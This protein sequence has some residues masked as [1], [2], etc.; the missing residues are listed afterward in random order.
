[1]TTK[2]RTPS[3]GRGETR[4]VTNGK[5]KRWA[6][7]FAAGVALA[8]PVRAGVEDVVV[9]FK[10][11]FDLGYTDMA[12]NVVHRYRTSMIDEALT[13]VD[14]N[15]DL[16]P[17]QQFVWTLAGWPLARIAGDWPGQSAERRA[18]VMAAFR[19]GR[20][21]VHALPF[22]LHTETLEPEDVVRGLEFARD[23]TRGA[24]LNLPRDAKMTDVPCHTWLLPTVL[25]RAGVEFL[26]LGC[27]A[28]SRSPEVPPLFWWEGPDGSRLLTM[29]TAESYGTGL[30]PP[31][32]WPYPV[33]LA[34][35][36]T[37]DNHGPPAPEE[38]RNLLAEAR[39][40][41]PGVRVRI[42]RLSDFSD[43][44]LARSPVVPVVRGDMPDTWIHGPQCD[45]A[46]AAMARRIRPRLE[47]AEILHTLLGVWG[48]AAADPAAVLAEAREH[49]LLY[50]EHTWGGALWWVVN[51]SGGARMPYGEAWQRERASGRLARIESSWEEHSAYIRRAAGLLEPI[52]RRQLDTLAAALDGQGPRRVV[53]NPLP[54]PRGGWVDAGDGSPGEWVEEVPALGYRRLPSVPGTASAEGPREAAAAAMPEN[55]TTV[56]AMENHWFRLALDPERARVVSLV[57]RRS[58]RDWADPEAPHGLGQV[59]LERFSAED[60]GAFVHAYV[61]IRADWATNELGKPNL[62]PSSEAPYR[63]WTPRQ[64]R[65]RILRGPHQTEARMETVGEG[66]LPAVTTRWILPAHAPYLDLEVTL[67]D[68]AADPWPEA[69]WIALPF[70]LAEP[71]FRLGR[72]GSI[73][74]PATDIVPGANRHL[75]AV[76]TG[77]ALLEGDDG[78]GV[79]LCPLDSGL[80]SLGEPG[81]WKYSREDPPRRAAVY[82]N[83]YNNQW[84]TNFR[85]WNGGTW[86]TRV[87]LWV[88]D[89][90]DA[91][92]SLITPALEARYPLLVGSAAAS[93][94]RLPASAEGLATDRRGILV[95]ALGADPDAVGGGLRLR[96]WE[97]AGRSGDVEVRL[98][99]SLAQGTVEAIDLR[100][101]T[102]P[103][104]RLTRDGSGRLR[105]ALPAFAPATVRLLR[106][107]P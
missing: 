21:A 86:T 28:A 82:V 13:V 83:V 25:R 31:A 60:A 46:G 70:D 100:G 7:L 39:A 23:L 81:C 51:Y 62:P 103:E 66:P 98:P 20:F 88:F 17:D 105:M 59:V 87:R 10:T 3:G 34:L 73:V 40:K 45:P 65:L 48:V 18:R 8:A 107:H 64:A 12:S 93:S 95:T 106:P 15:R 33:W 24:G 53:F 68:K 92:T 22:T 49:S 38:V 99:A 69:I 91:E 43:A 58:G 56:A 1:M 84:T 50:G 14:R 6:T 97:L 27:N 19:A 74:D 90:Y 42:G 104:T 79:G 78:P 30:V 4:G 32:D 76:Q 89:R 67:H 52:L 85:L 57:D 96:L 61:K 2:R 77:V 55:R 29:Y 44:L 75:F 54:W 101:Q 94:G 11:H 35:I 63:V 80:V 5:W 41:L 26:H 16:P 47:A 36:H 102:R 37:G 72:P 9:V 71:R